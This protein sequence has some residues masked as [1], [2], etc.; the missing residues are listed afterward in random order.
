M[1]RNQPW[2]T[3]VLAVAAFS[4]VV[5]PLVYAQS[6]PAGQVSS[7]M[8]SK[9][10][11]SSDFTAIQTKITASAG[12]D[13][14]GNRRT[15]RCN[16]KDPSASGDT[17]KQVNYTYKPLFPL[18][19][20][21]CTDDAILNFFAVNSSTEF[22]S[23]VQYLYN[24]QQSVSQL[25]GQLLTATFSPGFQ[26]VLST[27]VTA[28]SGSGSNTGTTN[29]S[30][31]TIRT[32]D[33]TPTASSGSTDTIAT[34]VSKI[35]AGG[36]FKV[37]FP[38]PVLFAQTLHGSFSG[39]FSPGI[40]FNIN[41]F[42]GQTTITDSSEYNLNFPFELYAQTKSIDPS[43]TGTGSVLFVDL[44]P[45]AEVISPAL[46]T[47]IGLVGS[48]GFFLG[49]AAAGI[50]FAQ[51]IRLSLQY[52]YGPEQV[53]QATSSTGSPA[54]TKSRISG[55]HLAVSFSPQKSKKQ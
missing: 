26:A 48:R 4:F 36:D 44:R 1:H 33:T 16:V 41:G 19:G 32:D 50:E 25:T 18:V 21:G 39:L 38:F 55:F 54:T 27:T 14:N 24:A 5:A 13:S 17:S 53:Y 35:E 12:T 42:T 7:R 49:Q 43:N 29:G 22:G 9:T 15:P 45:A 3:V 34:A 23:N 11:S 20:A 51:S 37:S 40:G 31:G 6:M 10:M 28:G 30:S 47:K 52:I 8:A 46:A 2:I